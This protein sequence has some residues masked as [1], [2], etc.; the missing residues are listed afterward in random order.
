MWRFLY[1]GKPI[2][3]DIKDTD[4]AKDAVKRGG[5]FM[6]D[7]YR[8][9]MEVTPP[10]KEN[11]APQYKITDVLEFTPADQDELATKEREDKRP[12]KRAGR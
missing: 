1:R 8:V 5:S 10:D 3:A 9:R 11:G 2:Y 12:G 4:I 6:N 7:R